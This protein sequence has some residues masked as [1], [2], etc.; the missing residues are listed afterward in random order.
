MPW[1]LAMEF[2]TITKNIIKYNKKIKIITLLF[3]LPPS[4]TLLLHLS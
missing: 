4:C 2:L 1:L 3:S